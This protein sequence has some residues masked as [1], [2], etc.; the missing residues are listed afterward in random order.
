M[1]VLECH[2]RLSLCS[3]ETDWFLYEMVKAQSNNWCQSQ[4]HG[5]EPR[6]HHLRRGIVGVQVWVTQ[7]LLMKCYKRFNL[8][9]WTLI[10]FKPGMGHTNDSGRMKVECLS[11]CVVSYG[12]RWRRRMKKLLLWGWGEG[13][14]C[15]LQKATRDGWARSGVRLE[16]VFGEVSKTGF[17]HLAKN[18]KN[19]II[20]H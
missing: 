18:F 2:K 16:I 8:P 19:S 20:S 15:R 6:E 7:M 1:I 3:Q 9:D 10:G 14:G 12:E 13:W 11:N 5:F 17:F 4:G